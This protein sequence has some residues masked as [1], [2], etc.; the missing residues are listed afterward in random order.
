MLYNSIKQLKL[1]LEL[2]LLEIEAYRALESETFDFGEGEMRNDGEYNLGSEDAYYE[3]EIQNIKDALL[4]LEYEHPNK[5]ETKNNNRLNRYHRKK[6]GKRKLKKLTNYNWWSAY[7][8]EDA[9][10]YKRCYLSGRKGFA[11]RCSNKKVRKELKFPLR[12]SGYKKCFD[13][14]WTVF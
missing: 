2:D 10:Y 11:K 4:D 6:V 1:E 9:G 3:M 7:Y 5:Q 12:G 14:W 13:Y 8:D